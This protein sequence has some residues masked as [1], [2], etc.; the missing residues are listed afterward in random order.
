M[1]AD[2]DQQWYPYQ[3]WRL[4]MLR[5]L[6]VLNALRAARG[7]PR[8]AIGIGLHTGNVVA[9]SIGSPR[10]LQYSYV[11]DTVNTASRIERLTRKL[12][13]E[14]LASGTTL[15]RAGGKAAFAAERMPSEPIPGK[16]EALSLW[17]VRGPARSD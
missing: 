14:L 7:E 1:L 13:C 2:L 12:D 16:R 3:V 17:A 11:G 9:G 8:I 4:G 15:A 10:L 5:R 6:A